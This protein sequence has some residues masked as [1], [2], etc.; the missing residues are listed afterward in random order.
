MAGGGGVEVGMRGAPVTTGLT[1]GMIGNFSNDDGNV[2][3]IICVIVTTSRLFQAL[4]HDNGVAVPQ[5]RNRYESR[6]V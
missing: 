3:E 6:L 5:E 4:K 2:N 1:T